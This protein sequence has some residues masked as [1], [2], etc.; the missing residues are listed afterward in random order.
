MSPLALVKDAANKM[1]V[2]GQQEPQGEQGIGESSD[3][4]GEQ[5]ERSDEQGE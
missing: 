1:D 2:T 3:E 4:Q 5:G